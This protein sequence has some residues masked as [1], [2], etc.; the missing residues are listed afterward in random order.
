MPL[1]QWL[2]IK[3]GIWKREDYIAPH[4]SGLQIMSGSLDKGFYLG[5]KEWLALLREGHRKLIYAGNDAHGNFNK[6]RQINIP[7]LSLWEKSEQIFGKWKTGVF[8]NGNNIK[9]ILI[10]LKNGN[11]IISDGPYLNFEILDGNQSY[12]IGNICQSN[13]ITIKIICESSADFGI[14]SVIKIFLG[15]LG[16]KE[17][18][19]RKIVPTN[20]TYNFVFEEESTIPSACYF[21]VELETRVLNKIHLA[22]TN[23]IWINP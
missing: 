18:C 14:I 23:P 17:I 3:R 4:V 7:M 9:D 5:K 15:Y 16:K 10:A 19:Y 6:F 8:A 22:M 11:C 13:K 12:E 21:R 20:E 2:L 1:L